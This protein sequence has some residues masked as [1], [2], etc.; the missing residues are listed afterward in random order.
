MFLNYFGLEF[1]NCIKVIRKSVI[2]MLLVVAAIIAAIVGSSML[3]M[4]SGVFKT[5]DVAIVLPE[6]KND[7]KWALDFLLSTESVKSVC[8]IKYFNELD[9]AKEELK[10]GR[11]K[12]IIMLEPDFYEDI[13][14]GVNTPVSIFIPDHVS[15]NTS[16]F[17]ELLQDAVNLLQVSQSGVYSAIDISREYSS[18]C[19]KHNVGDEVAII[20]AMAILARNSTFD[21]KVISA[22]GEA[23]LYQYYFTTLIIIVSLLLTINF[24][25]MYKKENLSLLQKLKVYGLSVPMQSLAKVGILTLI[26]WLIMLILYMIAYTISMVTGFYFLETGIGGAFLLLP[27][28]LSIAVFIHLVYAIVG[29]STYAGG[30]MLAIDLFMVLGSGLIVP[31]AYYPKCIQMAGKMMPV[32]LWNRYLQQSLFGGS[33]SVILIWVA[34]GIVIEFVIGTGILCRKK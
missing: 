6:E 27:V 10:E 25:H 19:V 15:L 13:D 28:A 26:M 21:K 1:K 17:L 7:S 18:E 8:D 9:A 4:K 3:L 2:S 24:S 29:E 5:I 16:V 20:Y 32:T 33:D 23:D 11:I 30:V 22:T 12:A 14:T 34:A 31:L